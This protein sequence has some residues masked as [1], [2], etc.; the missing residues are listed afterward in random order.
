LPHAKIFLLKKFTPGKGKPE[1]PW[2]TWKVVLVVLV[3]GSY[4]FVRRMLPHTIFQDGVQSARQ[5]H[6]LDGSETIISKKLV[7]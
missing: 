1:V 7:R 6:G 2:L 4:F 5:H 3:G